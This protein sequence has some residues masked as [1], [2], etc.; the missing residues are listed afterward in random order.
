MRDKS[1]I[2]TGYNGPPRRIPHC[3]SERCRSDK[4]LLDAAKR[5]SIS[6]CDEKWH[7]TCPRRLLGYKS[8]EGMEWCPAQHAEENAVSNAA[9][10]GASTI[11]TTLYL[12]SIVPCKNCFGT[13]INAGIV[14][15]VVESITF[16]DSLTKFLYAN[17]SIKIRE[18][19]L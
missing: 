8:S 16:Y 3:G 7:N 13:L 6:T 19:E 17:S 2:S 12:N 9:R 10:I 11:G 15:I 5:G 1:I 14:E 18:F 4:V